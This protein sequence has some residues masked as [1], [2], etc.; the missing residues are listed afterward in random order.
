MRFRKAAVLCLVLALVGA[1][2]WSFFL[3]RRPIALSRFPDEPRPYTLGGYFV[4]TLVYY[5][6]KDDRLN[7]CLWY[8]YWP[9]ERAC[10]M[11]R[12][13]LSDRLAEPA[14]TKHNGRL[15]TY[16]RDLTVLRQDHADGF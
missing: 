10:G 9:M 4:T 2:I 13:S 15:P 14:D 3:V 16:V 12:R 6:S 11:D 8:F 1:Y 5:F 7:S